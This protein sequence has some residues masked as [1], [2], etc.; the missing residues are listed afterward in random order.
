MKKIVLLLLFALS[1]TVFNACNDGNAGTTITANNE[2]VTF[3]EVPLIC[4][5]HKEI[6]C[7][8]RAK[9]ALLD[10]EK[11]PAIAEAWLN[12]QGTVY[13][14]VWKGDAQTRNI[15]KP[16]F[17]KYSIDYD[18]LDETDAKNNLKTFRAENKWYRGADVDKLS[19]EEASH[20]ASTISNFALERKLMSQDEVNVLKPK[21]ENYFKAELVKVRTPEQLYDDSENK[22]S[23]DLIAM[24]EPILGVERT[25]DILTKWQTFQMEECKK[26]ESCKSGPMKDCC[27]KK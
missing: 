23:H 12:R 11:N 24:S 15:A 17:D 5:A 27:K 18:V 22:F 20:I 1:T 21:V 3:Y 25:K 8:S 6:G 7:G 14:I 2:N 4:N 13:A 26:D 19:I 9:P 16:I 10:M